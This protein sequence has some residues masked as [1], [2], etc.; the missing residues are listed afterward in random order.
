MSTPDL[1]EHPTVDETPDATVEVIHQPDHLW[2][3]NGY[4]DL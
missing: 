1:T 4:I 2:A 3:G